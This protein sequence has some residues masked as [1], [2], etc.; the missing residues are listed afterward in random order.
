MNLGES[1]LSQKTS[2]FELQVARFQQFLRANQR[3]EKIVWIE[4]GDLLLTG[5]RHLYA[6]IPTS[7]SRELAA[8]RAF[9]KGIEQGRG[10]L[11]K[12]VFEVQGSSLC[13]VWVPRNNDEASLALMPAGVKLSILNSN[14]PVTAI[15]SPFLWLW[16]KIRFSGTQGAKENYFGEFVVLPPM[17][18]R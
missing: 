17:N 15:E 2:N 1:K 8:R 3:S 13:Y 14:I 4:L 7:D 18:A 5:K 6:R 9:E 12:A 16:L 11:F 10:V